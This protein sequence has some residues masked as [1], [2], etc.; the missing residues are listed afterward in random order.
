MKRIGKRCWSFIKKRAAGLPGILREKTGLRFRR[1]AFGKI[2]RQALALAAFAAAVIVSPF[3]GADAEAGQG[4]PDAS[5][6]VY[7]DSDYG[8]VPDEELAAGIPDIPL[9]NVLSFTSYTVEKDDTISAIAGKM[10]LN[11]D[12][13]IS[14][15][16][17]ERARSLQI[18]TVLRI[19]NMNGIMHTIKAGD[20]LE[21]LAETYQVQPEQLLE[22]NNIGEFVG[23]AGQKIFI[24]EA[25]LSSLE[26]RRVWGELFRY[27]VRGWITSR[28]GYRNDPFSGE[29]R[30][31]NGIDIAGSFGAPVGA[32]MEGRVIEAG[33]NNISG[34]YVVV[35]HSGGYV[36]S[37]AHLSLIRVKQGQWVT[38]G[39]RLGDI[40]STGYS[41]G[42]HL[43]F[44]ISRWGK[45]VNPV[46]LLH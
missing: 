45:S 32:A 5:L 12:S 30:F 44:S 9:K 10:Q 35:A 34:N 31:H 22:V 1:R 19:P 24:P 28:Y 23:E 37:Y 29:R 11:Q 33:Y 6:A 3:S 26:L 14:C 7:L 18:G 16:A 42:N 13:I 38:E 41:T 4:Q 15:N 39:Q 40:G 27:P 8:T 46:L 17:I 43:H 25:K 2:I 21:K 36:T 20:S